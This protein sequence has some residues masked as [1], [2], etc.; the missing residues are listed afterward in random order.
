MSPSIIESPRVC[1]FISRTAWL[2]QQQGQRALLRPGS[3]SLSW[4]F[5]SRVKPFINGFTAELF[6]LLPQE[7]FN[8]HV[9]ICNSLQGNKAMPNTIITPKTNSH[10]KAARVPYK[11]SSL[12][13]SGQ[14]L[15]MYRWTVQ[16]AEV[17][18]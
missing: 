17:N 14:R 5:Y 1:F 16:T 8:F 10:P 6:V 9:N 13:K 2:E 18:V 15:H 4:W 11:V 7:W 12:L 3:S